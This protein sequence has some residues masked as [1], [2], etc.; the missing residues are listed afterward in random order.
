MLRR[1]YYFLYLLTMGGQFMVF[2]RLRRLLLNGMLGRK[3]IGLHIGPN[4][5]IQGWRNL[6]LGDHV[7]IHQ[8]ATLSCEGGLEIGDYVGIGHGASIVTTEHGYSDH[9]L[10]IRQQP[11]SSAKVT[12]HDNVMICARAI[13][14]A[15]VSIAEGTVVG[16]NATVTKSIDEQDTIV[17]GSPARK[18]KDRLWLAGIYAPVMVA[19][20]W[21]DTL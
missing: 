4:V 14:L 8:F 16:A 18:I 7:S 1:F 2:V 20:T 11:V 5:H 15:G 19:A 13:V 10:P 9:S 17:A 21:M 3:H 12:I 6:R